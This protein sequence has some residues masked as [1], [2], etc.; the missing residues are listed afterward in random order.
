MWGE[1]EEGW[2]LWPSRTGAFSG[3]GWTYLHRGERSEVVDVK[4]DRCVYLLWVR[5]EA[6]KRAGGLW[7]SLRFLELD[8]LCGGALPLGVAAALV[9]HEAG[10]GG[11]E[12]DD[13]DDDGAGDDCVDPALDGGWS[14]LLVGLGY[15]E[16]CE[17][18]DKDEKHRCV[19]DVSLV[20]VSLGGDG[21]D[22]L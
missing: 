1:E 6:G 20:G 14:G 3:R 2:I 9:T 22:L 10:T 7:S 4:V 18:E 15:S 17:D 8:A 11:C 5:V 13:G 16:G 19:Q 21:V 12:D